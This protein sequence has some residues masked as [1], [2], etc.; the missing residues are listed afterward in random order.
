[1]SPET[2]GKANFRSA[3]QR[4]YQCYSP[5]STTPRNACDRQFH[6]NLVAA[7]VSAY[8]DGSSA[9]RS[10]CIYAANSY[11]VAVRNIGG[12]F[13]KGKGVNG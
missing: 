10:N 9:G 2:W 5:T 3:C 7:C 11:F 6:V 12:A 1:M 4:H 8:P 13:Y